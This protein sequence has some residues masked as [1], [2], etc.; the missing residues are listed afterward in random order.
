MEETI[1]K[2]HKD[3]LFC[4]I[5]G[6]AENR[7]WTLSLYNAVNGTDY[8]DPDEVDITTMGDYIYM[9]MKN[10]VSFLINCD[11]SLYEQ[12][13]SYNPNM[14]VRLLMYLG[15][16][17]DKY[18]KK[19]KQNVYGRKQM[20]LPMPRLVTF[21][22]GVESVNNQVLR[23]SDSFPEDSDSNKSDVQVTVHL[24]NIASEESNHLIR[25][26][27]PLAEYSWFIEAIRKNRKMMGL[28]PAIDKAIKDMPSDYA[29][30]DF[31]VGH[32]AEVR[33]MC[34][35]EYNEAETMQMFK[36]EGREEGREAQLISQVCRKLRK[37]KNVGQIADELEEDEIR[38]K[39]IC[40][41]AEAFFPDYDEE[42]VIS[43][44][45]QNALV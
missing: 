12:Q 10:D 6:S 43:A 1:N 22:N 18:I 7:K 45:R 26:C 25:D 30:K 28:E 42:E 21:Y 44:I 41:V 5:F 33:D 15:R 29:I 36:E 8:S 37:G 23:L 38:I 32:Q 39:A 2:E 34:I 24:Y 40:D 14:P 16:Q 35:T 13:S 9:G 27:K 11:L 20:V 4:Y 31:L 3:R 19:T 17:Y